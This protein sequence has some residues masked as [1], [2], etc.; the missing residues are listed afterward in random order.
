MAVG[1]GVAVFGVIID[2]GGIGMVT[3]S[4]KDGVRL[5]IIKDMACRAMLVVGAFS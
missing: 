1:S 2:R 4:R 5:M 3:L